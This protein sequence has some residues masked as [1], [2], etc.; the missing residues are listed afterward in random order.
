MSVKTKIFGLV[1]VIAAV[2]LITGI[3]AVGCAQEGTATKPEANTKSWKNADFNTAVPD[4]KLPRGIRFKNAKGWEFKGED[5]LVPAVWRIPSNA[6]GSYEKESE[7][8]YFIRLKEGH[9]M[10][11]FLPQ[12]QDK[13]ILKISFKARGKGPITLWTC[14]YKNKNEQN[15]KGYD[16]LMETQK[17][18]K[19]DLM[20]DWQT[21]QFE[22]ETAGVP[23]ERVAVR[24][25][26]LPMC[27]LLDLDDVYVTVVPVK[28]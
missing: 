3:A 27:E 9:V 16:I 1:E 25:N 8:N 28:K 26:V 12:T 22:T 6:A 4:S 14:S 5:E 18:Q 2:S 23:T 7:R 20:P 11:Y 17:N 13:C 15:S 10:Q 19:Y 21:Y 24:F